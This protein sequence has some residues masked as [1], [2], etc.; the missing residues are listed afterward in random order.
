MMQRVP[1]SSFLNMLMQM[2]GTFARRSKQRFVS[3]MT[4]FPQDTQ[5][6]IYQ[7]QSKIHQFSQKLEIDA[8][9]D[10][11]TMSLRPIINGSSDRPHMSV[12]D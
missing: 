2:G 10:D 8:Y 6:F 4:F 1:I 9:N 7:Y 5:N 3:Y 12:N 11:F